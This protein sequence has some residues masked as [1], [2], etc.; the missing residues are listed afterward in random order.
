MTILSRVPAHLFVDVT[1]P[2]I[3]LDAF[4]EKYASVDRPPLFI[5]G[6]KTRNQFSSR[7][8]RGRDGSKGS[9]N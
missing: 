8:R 6:F 4:T 5:L 7:R 3:A 2:T 9:F 1:F